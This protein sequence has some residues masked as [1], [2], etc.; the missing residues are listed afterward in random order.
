MLPS[1]R[2][3]SRFAAL[4]LNGFTGFKVAFPAWFV[5][6]VACLRAFLGAGTPSPVGDDG[7]PPLLELEADKAIGRAPVDSGV[8]GMGVVDADELAEAIEEQR[9]VRRRGGYRV[10]QV[11]I[12]GS[13]RGMLRFN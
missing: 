7:I 6:S 12:P 3:L 8:R 13:V 9:V 10:R 1:A 11:Q 2:T 5:Y 4:R